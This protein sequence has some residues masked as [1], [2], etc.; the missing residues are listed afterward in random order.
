MQ[1]VD[2]APASTVMMNSFNFNF[3]I[4]TFPTYKIKVFHKVRMCL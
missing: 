4:E 2:I 1:K 3:I